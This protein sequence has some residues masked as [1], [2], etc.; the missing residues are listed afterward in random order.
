MS[1]LTRWNRA[2]LSRFSYVDGNAAVFLERLRAGL[3]DR[4]PLWLPV[5]GGTPPLDGESEEAKKA[6]IENLYTADPG[7]ML[8]Q[9]TRQFARSCHVLGGH[10]DGFANEATLETASQWEN[11]RRLVALLNYAPLP[12]ASASVPLALQVKVGKSGTIAAGFQVKHAP[13][14]GKPVIFETLEEICVDAAYNILRAKGH[15]ISPVGLFGNEL[16]LVGRLDKV[17]IGTPLV[18]ENQV[19][20]KLSAHLVQGIVLE[21]KQTAL[22]LTPGIPAGFTRGTTLVHCCPKE[23]LK[24]LGPATKGV[25]AV[26]HSLQLA[27][28]S[29]GLAPG[30]IVVIRSEDNKPLYRRIKAVHDDRLVFY[31]PINQLTLNGAT[32]ARPVTLPLTELVNPPKGRVILEA[33]KDGQ[34]KGTVVDIVYAAGDWSRLEGQWLADIVERGKGASKREYLPAY[35]CLHTKYVPV[36]TDSSF[37]EDGDRPGYTTLTLTWHQDTDGIPG[38]LDLRLKNP[39]ALL[40]PPT[41]PG[42]WAVDTFLNKSE[43]GRLIRELVTETSKQATSGDLAVVVKGGQLAWTRLGTVAHDREHEETILGAEPLWQD[44]GGGPFFL[45]RTRVHTHF[46]QQARLVGWTENNTAIS[47]RRIFLQAPLLGTKAGRLVLVGN[48]TSV[49]QSR[50]EEMD[51]NGVWLQLSDTPPSGTTIGNL[52][53]LANVLIAG[54][55]ETRPWRVLGSGDGSRNNQ[56]FALEVEDLSFVG[57]TAM[58]TGVRAALEVVIGGE[59]WTQ[60]DNL[61]DS[62]ASDAHYQVRINEDG[63]TVIAFGDGRHGRRLPSGTNNIRIRLRQGVGMAGNLDP[64]CLVKPMQPHPLIASIRQPL[65]SSGGNDR[66]G[67]ADL[68]RNAPA[69]LLALN[70]AVSIE[71]AAQLAR[72]HPSVWQA[73]AFRLKPGLGR[74]ERLEVVVMAAGGGFLSTSLKQSVQ[75]WLTARCQPGMQVL[76]TDYVPVRFRLEV[77][78]RIRTTMD[79]QSVKEAVETSLIDG[80]DL[81]RR[82]LGQPLYRGEIYSLVDAVA[83]VENSSCALVFFWPQAGVPVDDRPRV[84]IAGNTVMSISPSPRQCLV[85]DSATLNVRLEA[86]EE[87]LT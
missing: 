65:A 56:S 11:L 21:E 9:L 84:A 38:D 50:I 54:H 37:V 73:A 5:P 85:L 70:R 22:T 53:I 1:D 83:G 15:Q 69:S 24:P 13:A 64:G 57:D 63:Y 19:T 58:A 41:E 66:E 48:G 43:E 27:S 51:A 39:Q 33:D 32:V 14:N 29:K 78:V 67:N 59:S 31:R 47:S 4:F 60:V 17:G 68:R 44:R 8:W 45:S 62:S 76:L 81:S 35:N 86:A 75:S 30:D 52:E 40:A 74:R 26:G 23:R 10:I 16:L 6:R 25:E 18:L 80:L 79:S 72:S 77:T 28:S 61:K 49:I 42:P 2:G 71:D 82:Q 34:V 3:A 12:P 36:D 20:S 55:G 7:D 87:G 46:T